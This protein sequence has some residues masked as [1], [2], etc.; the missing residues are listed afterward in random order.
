MANRVKDKTGEKYGRLTVIEPVGI[1]KD[2]SM[3]FKCHCECGNET[4]VSSANLRKGKYSTLSCGCLKK[5]SYNSIK[6]SIA[7]SEKLK[8]KNEFIFMSDYVIGI[9]TGGEKFY[10]DKEDYKKVKE[11]RWA[12][13]THGYITANVSIIGKKGKHTRIQLQRLI[14]NFP[15]GKDVDH[16]NH[17][18]TDNRKSN[19]RICTH[20]QNGFNRKVKGYYFDKGIKKWRS[21]ISKNRKTIHLGS[22]ATEQEA[23]MVRKQAEEKYFGEHRYQEIVGG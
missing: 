18:L 8:K 12:V 10:F 21:T 20:Q 14:M 2:R 23:I 3:W 1:G 19:L 4:I 22:F 6:R 17:D 7:I 15:K 13:G 16:I 5:E 11:Y 9:A